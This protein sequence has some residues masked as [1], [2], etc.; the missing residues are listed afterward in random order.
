MVDPVVGSPRSISWQKE[1]VQESI[2]PFKV[3]SFAVALILGGGAIF[4]AYLGVGTVG[5]GILAGGAGAA[6]LAILTTYFLTYEPHCQRLL[7]KAID[8]TLTRKM[9]F[10]MGEGVRML[11]RGDFAKLKVLTSFIRDIDYQI[12]SNETALHKAASLTGRSRKRG[13]GNVGDPRAID[14]LCSLGADPNARDKDG[15]TPLHHLAV[16]NPRLENIRVLQ[17]HGADVKAEN[18]KKETPFDSLVNAKHIN[19]STYLRYAASKRALQLSLE[20]ESIIDL[21][22]SV[23][24]AGHQRAGLPCLSEKDYEN[25]EDWWFM[26]FNFKIEGGQTPL[27][28][29]ASV[30][31]LE[32]MYTGSGRIGDPRAIYLLYKNSADPNAPDDKGNTPLHIAAGEHANPENIVALRE[33]G[34]DPSVRNLDG[35]TP[36]QE[37]EHNHSTLG[38][39]T[40]IG[41]DHALRDDLESLASQ[42]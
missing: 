20:E 40:R 26:N 7:H 42:L 27:H 29:A 38:S 3:T 35:R 30:L 39:L 8:K 33:C 25:L 18:A 4:A 13:E 17:Y 2:T 37:W 15:N 32:K 22:S 19:P 36:E 6:V 23:A 41:I 10:S 9:S 14:L 16:S 1:L 11:K 28:L 24:P 5:V 12:D 34:A 21:L 31:A